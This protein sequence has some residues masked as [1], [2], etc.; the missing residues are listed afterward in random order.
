[1]SRGLLALSLGAVGVVYGD[2]GASPLYAVRETLAHARP[3]GSWPVSVLGVISLILYALTLVVTIKYVTVLMRADNR[4][5]GGPVALM[6][7]AQRA[8]GR[9]SNLLFFFGVIGVAFF[10]ADGV[11]TPAFSV[12]SAVEG[13][14]HA[15]QIGPYFAPYVLAAAGGI[16]IALFLVQSRGTEGVARLF[17]PITAAWFITLAVLGILKIWEAPDILRAINPLYAV[18][19]LVHNGLLG[20]IIL[21]GVFLAVTGAEALYADMGHF[22]KT[23]I[24]FAWFAFVFPCLM[25]NYLGQGAFILHH[26]AAKADPF[27]Q[28][29]PHDVYW[30][31]LAL[32][33][34]AAVIAS[35]AVITGAFSLTRQAVLLN[36]LPRLDIRPT[37]GRQSGQIFVPA[38]NTMMMIGV[39]VLLMVFRTSHNLAAAYGAAVT[40]TM[41]ISTV[42]ATFVARHHWGW[43]NFR[44]ALIFAPI[45]ALDLVFFGSNLVK[46]R[47][48]AWLTFVFGAGLAIIMMTWSRGVRVLVEKITAESVPL[49]DLI[50]AVSARPP[51]RQPGVAVF[52]TA[53]PDAAPM[54]LSH[55]LKH[56]QVLHEKNVILSVQ[57][58]EQPRIPEDQR[59]QLTP[60]D[61][62]FWRLVLTFGFMDEPDVPA[63]LAACRK[64][65]LNFNI[66]ST[67]FFIGRR[68][69]VADPRSPLPAWQDRIFIFL[70]K[71]AAHPT[72]F[73]HMPPGRVVE[74]GAQIAV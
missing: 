12:L 26:K 25:L 19:F 44:T 18:R 14:K 20:F 22:G 7:L 45:F 3:V 17:G 34:A 38:V 69:V 23:P 15:P 24:R 1:M 39:L 9:P 41:A 8:L 66:M 72:A 58:S 16:L 30:P 33:T 32:A 35:Q 70:M 50:K 11:V 4:G 42:M 46:I 71:N 53:N 28:M 54:A 27:F 37:S 48:G 2:I 43:S 55:N 49:T 10:Y 13:L 73:F 60:I 51:R 52:L 59:I 57:I 67:S 6:A 5:E 36:L 40:A 21:G 64:L 61:E 68:A 47:D 62:N 29:V 63:A 65:G 74:L 56:N 31:V